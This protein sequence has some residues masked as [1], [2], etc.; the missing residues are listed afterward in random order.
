MA[1]ETRG[2]YIETKKNNF[3]T[4]KKQG[5]KNDVIFV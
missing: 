5:R 3:V 4:K 1:P 2:T